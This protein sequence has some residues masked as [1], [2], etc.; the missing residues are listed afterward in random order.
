MPCSDV[1]SQT[2]SYA[3]TK[4]FTEIQKSATR[5][6]MAVNCMFYKVN[7]AWNSMIGGVFCTETKLFVINYFFFFHL[8][9]ISI[10]LSITFSN[11]L[12]NI[13]SIKVG[14]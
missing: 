4:S 14:L 6:F 12:F 5:K 13:D 8:K 1:V 3:D 10:L 9:K 11:S 2:K 7:D